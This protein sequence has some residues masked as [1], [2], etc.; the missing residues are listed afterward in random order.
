MFACTPIT[1]EHYAVVLQLLCSV[2]KDP[3]NFLNLPFA[4][5]DVVYVNIIK[6]LS[7]GMETVMEFHC[8]TKLLITQEG[9]IYLCMYLFI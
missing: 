6:A 9:F 2:Y 4:Y 3:P 5:V 7:L 8:T 1:G